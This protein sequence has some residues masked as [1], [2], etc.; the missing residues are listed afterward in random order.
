MFG[1]SEKFD[2]GAWM[3]WLWFGCNPA[4]IKFMGS[5]DYPKTAHPTAQF[6][7]PG[8]HMAVTEFSLIVK[9]ILESDQSR[10]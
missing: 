9:Q 4:A 6:V 7:V 1:V 2:G 5:T 10:E 8:E 3:V